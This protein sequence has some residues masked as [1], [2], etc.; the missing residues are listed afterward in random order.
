MEHDVGRRARELRVDG[1]AAANDWLM[2]YQADLLGIPVVRPRVV[3]TTALGA[4]LLAGLG[5]GFWSSHA[6][7]ERARRIEKVVR[8]KQPPAWRTAENAR[9]N[10]AVSALLAPGAARA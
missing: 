4:G 10:A 8:P 6:D 1:G 5:T 2:Q 7:L 9:W 3:E